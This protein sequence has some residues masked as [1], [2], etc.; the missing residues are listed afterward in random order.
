M[1]L[2]ERAKEV[3]DN[4]NKSWQ[5]AWSDARLTTLVDVITWKLRRGYNAFFQARA[6]AVVSDS[7]VYDEKIWKAIEEAFVDGFNYL[8]ELERR[9]EN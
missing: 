4:R 7:F 2:D 6:R 1:K 3:Q 9:I 5:D 8:K